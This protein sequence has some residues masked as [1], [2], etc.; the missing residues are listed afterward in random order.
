[1]RLRLTLEA[2][3]AALLLALMLAA[4]GV[5]ATLEHYLAGRSLGALAWTALALGALAVAVW[6]A[7]RALRPV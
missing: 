2:R 4:A 5:A 6:G 1:M 3:L 7:H